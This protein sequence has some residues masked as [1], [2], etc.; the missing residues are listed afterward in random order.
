MPRRSDPR[1]LVALL[2]AALPV[3]SCA[4]SGAGPLGI[5]AIVGHRNLAAAEPLFSKQEE[6]CLGSADRLIGIV[7]GGAGGDQS[8]VPNKSTAACARIRSNFRYLILPSTPGGP[9]RYDIAQRNEIIDV[10]LATSNRKCTRYS[11]LLKNADGAM[12]SGLSVGAIITGG[13]GSILGG[14]NTAK[15]LAG[16]S[17]ILS[18][19]RAALND[20]Y[21]S[22]QTIHVLTAAFDKARRA[23][24]RIITNRQACTVDQYT[25][26]RGIEDAFAYH[27]SCSLVAGLAETA[28][29][30]ERSENPELDAMRM[31][32][33]ELTNLRRQAAELGSTGPI[34]PIAASPTPPSVDKL[35]TADKAFTAAQQ[36]L[37]AAETARDSAKAGLA[38]A[39]L[40]LAKQTATDKSAEIAAVAAATAK[41]KTEDGTVLKLTN[42]RNAAVRTRDDEV[43]ALVKVTMPAPAIVDPETRVCPFT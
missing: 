33:N 36:A 27:Q 3:G 12:N 40:A 34:T 41:L 37:I 24:R 16:S 14:V 28:L 19:S 21:L 2:V 42:L 39:S 18:G 43:L 7:F 30:I 20:T 31:Q 23:Q 29:S 32:L 17:S 1:M 5:G 13:L 22:N 11:S 38:A 4:G 9:P 26:M 35:V 6:D 8:G 10:L 25:L 15:A